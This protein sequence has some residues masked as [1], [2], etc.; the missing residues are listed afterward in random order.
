MKLTAEEYE[1]IKFYNNATSC[2]RPDGILVL[3]HY[4]LRAGKRIIH[5]LIKKGVLEWNEE[6]SVNGI[7]SP[8]KRGENYISSI[9]LYC[10][11][12]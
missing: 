8:I 1:F 3:R 9:K 11:E 2:R 6:D 12:Q 5:S 7:Y 10:E 4:G